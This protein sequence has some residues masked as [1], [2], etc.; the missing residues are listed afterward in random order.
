MLASWNNPFYQA[1]VAPRTVG[2]ETVSETVGFAPRL[3]FAYD[4]TDDH[5]TVLKM[6]YGRFIFNSAD[7]VA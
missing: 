6:F 5:R 4:L 3:G 1:F 7:D 2:A